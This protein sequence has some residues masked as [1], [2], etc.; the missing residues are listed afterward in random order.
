MRSLNVKLIVAFLVISLVGTVLVAL[1]VAQTTRNQ[2][3][4]FVLDQYQERVVDRWAAYYRAKGSWEG[5][6]EAVPLP[7]P[8]FGEER[9]GTDH[10]KYLF[11]SP[12]PADLLQ[13]VREQSWRPTVVDGGGRVVVAGPHYH[14]GEQV[15]DDK[16]EGGIPIRIDGAVVGIMIGGFR[17]DGKLSAQERFLNRFFTAL[18]VGGIGATIFA[19][20]L[21][22][23]LS[24]SLTKPLRE[25][26]TATQA[27]AKGD[28]EQRI[29]VRSRDELGELAQSFN[30]MSAELVS[31]RKQRRQMTADIAHELRT[32]LSLILGHAEALND[33]VLPPSPETFDIIH[34]EAQRLSRL[35]E[36]LRTL[37]LSDAGALP[38][39]R[40]LVSPQALLQRVVAAHTLHSQQK[41]ISVDI[42]AAPSVPEVNVDPDRM[43]QV[44]DNLLDNALRH[45]P[46]NGHI[47]LSAR[48]S[49]AGV[50]IAV[51]DSGPGIPPEDVERVFDRLYRG[52]KSRQRHEGGSGL[53]L[54][55]AKSIVESHDGRIWAESKPG[56]GATFIVELP[57][58]A[59]NVVQE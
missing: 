52:D 32:P 48:S 43:A 50:R 51:R 22:V 17:P 31:A 53:G 21:G 10:T 54:A 25:L 33:G 7:P 37:S 20:A 41:N 14:L 16:I 3:G 23:L 9:G 4:R 26:T 15:P 55:I 19:L 47:A 34:D 5:A 1:Y 30:R 42:E 58:R 38:L 35:V 46:A 57:T 11:P 8:R 18:L 29:P 12:W 56:E 2:L 24:R 39:A 49:S 6:D 44:L 45:T 59:A 13:D 36:D 40:R 27:M 28:L